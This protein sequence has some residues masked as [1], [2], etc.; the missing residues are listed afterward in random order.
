MDLARLLDSTLGIYTVLT[1]VVVVGLTAALAVVRLNAAFVPIRTWLVMLPVILGALWLG[2]P[3]WT[4][5]VTVVSILGFREFARA[6]GLHRE[7]GI[8]AIV[9]LA[10]V[11]ENIAAALDRYDVFNAVPMW[12][13]FL[14]ALVPILVNKAERMLQWLSL[15]TL[16][17]LF[18]GYFLAHLTY[19]ANS[20]AGLGFVLY[21]TLGTQLNDAF[22]FIYGKLFGRRHWTVLSPNKTIEGS[23]L[24]AGTTIAL[25]FAQWWLAFPQLPAVAVLVAGVIVGLGGQGGDLMMATVKRNVGIK[26]FGNLLPGHGGITD[27]VNSLM[28]TAPV[29]AHVIGFIWGG[30]PGAD[31]GWIRGMGA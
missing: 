6:T 8:T 25:A 30:F 12:T 29:F 4:V 23:L 5:V 1:I 10:I 28:V 2:L 24:A 27:R 15:A 9:Y 18:Y 21:V 19:L 22:G 3:A 11:I 17:V 31:P 13:I 7:L 26:D 14:V 20:P 16:G